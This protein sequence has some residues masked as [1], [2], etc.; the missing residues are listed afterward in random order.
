MKGVSGKVNCRNVIWEKPCSIFAVCN[1]LTLKVSEV[2]FSSN[3]I[4]DSLNYSYYC[5]VASGMVDNI[6]LANELPA[7][8]NGDKAFVLAFCLS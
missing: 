5:S 4:D 8:V 6:N 3:N 1:L 7:I 2:Y